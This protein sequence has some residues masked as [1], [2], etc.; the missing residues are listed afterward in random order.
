[1]VLNNLFQKIEGLFNIGNCGAAGNYG[2][3]EI[4][5]GLGDRVNRCTNLAEDEY[6]MIYSMI[7]KGSIEFEVDR[8]KDGRIKVKK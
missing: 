7:T 8:N 4:I 2:R 1:V 5:G 3:I 6:L